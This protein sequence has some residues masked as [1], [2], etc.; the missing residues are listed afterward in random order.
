[1][2]YR[3]LFFFP[4][5]T[6]AVLL[7]IGF[8]KLYG[9]ATR[10]DVPTPVSA[11]VAH[12]A[13][14][15]A[16]GVPM[17]Q[18]AAAL[19]GAAWIPNVGYV[20]ALPGNRTVAQVRLFPGAAER[21]KAAAS[22]DAPVAGVEMVSVKSED[23]PRA[24]QD[25]GIVF[26]GAPKDGCIIPVYAEAPFRRVMYWTTKNDR[27][28]VALISDWK[29]QGPPRPGLVVWSMLAWAGP[30]KG[31]ETLLANFDARSCLTVAGT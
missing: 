18:S 27:G 29:R 3:P 25:L 6:I 1:M 26:R 2:G 31:S 9:R 5:M 21:A 15:V 10:P 28:G 16:L 30:F 11:T 24:M 4:A 19:R 14:G 7:A 23:M 20:G 12:F 8:F 17:K 22:E 13:P